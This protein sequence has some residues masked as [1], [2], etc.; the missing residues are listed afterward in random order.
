L[1]DVAI[2]PG[3]QPQVHIDIQPAD[4]P[5]WLIEP[6]VI[7]HGVI[8]QPAIVGIGPPLI[9]DEI[10]AAQG[11]DHIRR[12]PGINHIAGCGMTRP[13]RRKAAGDLVGS[14]RDHA[15]GG[16][17]IAACKRRQKLG[18]ADRKARDLQNLAPQGVVVMHLGQAARRHA[19]LSGIRPILNDI[20]GKALEDKADTGSHD[21]GIQRAC[22][23]QRHPR[24]GQG[25]HGVIAK[26]AIAI[27]AQISSHPLQLC[28]ETHPFKVNSLLTPPKVAKVNVWL[29]GST[30]PRGA[31]IL[32]RLG[33]H[34]AKA[35]PDVAN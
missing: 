35:T 30:F 26:L 18:Q 10:I 22:R 21:L 34:P 23:C 3:D 14:M 2:R 13:R 4:H 11:V 27:K 7:G 32:L 25:R 9:L 5:L 33:R 31:V 20:R 29:S 28:H 8:A 6:A 17:G 12:S 24:W 16:K 15:P 1:I 19:F